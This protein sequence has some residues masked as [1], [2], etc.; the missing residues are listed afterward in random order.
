M[1]PGRPSYKLLRTTVKRENDKI[2]KKKRSAD[3]SLKSVGLE[4]KLSIRLKLITTVTCLA[5]AYKDRIA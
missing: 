3:W 1:A 5:K 2:L 4:T